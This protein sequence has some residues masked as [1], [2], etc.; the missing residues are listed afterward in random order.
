M[1]DD[2]RAVF[3]FPELGLIGLFSSLWHLPSSLLLHKLPDWFQ[4]GFDLRICL[5]RCV[6]FLSCMAPMFLVAPLWFL[7][8]I[9]C[10][11]SL[12]SPDALLCCS[13]GISQW[14]YFVT[15]F[16]SLLSVCGPKKHFSWHF[17]VLLHSVSHCRQS[18]FSRPACSIHIL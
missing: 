3:G 16:M 7:M 12:L 6:L 2:Q 8:P 11:I 9:F 13:E 14:S 5:N 15:H 4:V 10:S 18:L 1:T 17:A